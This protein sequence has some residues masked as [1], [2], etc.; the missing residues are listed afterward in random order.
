MKLR[1][2]YTCPLELTHD[3]IRGKWKPIILWQLGK[4]PASLSTLQKDIAGV[5]QKMLLQHLGELQNFGMVQKEQ[6]E[7]YPLKV[8][9]AL[10]DKGKRMVRIIAAMQEV[11]I[12]LM[13]EDGKEEFLKNK[14]L[15]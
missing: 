15:L 8:E 9:Y 6:Y 14:G 4:A 5:G 2:S 12:E 3:I 7:G 10:T 11:G 1:D 13:M